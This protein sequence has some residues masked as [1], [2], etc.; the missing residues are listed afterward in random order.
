MVLAS[1]ASI[2][3]QFPYRSRTPLAF[4]T[5][6][7]APPRQHDPLDHRPPPPTRP[8]LAPIYLVLRPILPWRAI[9][10]HKITQRRPPRRDRPAQRPLD[11][12]VQSAHHLPRHG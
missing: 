9:R 10:V 1:P 6:T 2:F 8:P 12:P 7:R 3:K 11:R 4:R 5:I